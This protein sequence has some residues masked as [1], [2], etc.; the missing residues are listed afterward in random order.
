MA[1]SVKSAH[2]HVALQHLQA[3]GARPPRV[4]PTQRLRL[5]EVDPLEV[6]A[7]EHPQPAAA[8]A[9]ERDLLRQVITCVS[10]HVHVKVHIHQ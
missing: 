4:R 6:A 8:A 5:G 1:T 2:A 7:L 10:Q 3:H 9:V